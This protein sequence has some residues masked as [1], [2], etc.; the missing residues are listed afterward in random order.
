MKYWVITDTHFGHDEMVNR[1][2]RPVDFSFTILRHLHRMVTDKDVIIHLGDICFGKEAFWHDELAKVPG[3]KWLTM[4]N[5]DGKCVSKDTRILTVGGYKRWDEIEIGESIPTVNLQTGK[6]EFNPVLDKYVYVKEPFIYR[7][8]HG[9]GHME[10]S[11][12]HAII[13]QSGLEKRTEKWKKNLAENVWGAKNEIVIP[14]CFSSAGTYSMSLDLLKM[15]AW[16]A[17]D[18]SVTKSKNVILYQSKIQYIQEI[19]DLMGRLGLEYTERVRERKIE[20]ICGKAIKSTLP[21]HEF[22]LSIKSSLEI[23]SLLKLDGK[24]HF[25]AWLW[26]ISDEDFEIFINEVVKGDGTFRLN[27]HRVIWGNKKWLE[28][29]MGLCVTHGIHAN[30]KKQSGKENYYLG[31]RGTA[32]YKQFA[33]KHLSKVPYDDM[34]W[35]INVK[36]NSFFAELNG[37]TFVTGNSS[38]WYLEHGWDFVAHN[39]TL[40]IYGHSILLSHVPEKD[41]GQYT[42]EIHGHF[43]NFDHRKYE[44]EFVAIANGKQCVMSI[45]T[46]NYQPVLLQTVVEAFNKRPDLEQPFYYA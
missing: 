6:V 30:L 25:P 38:S 20:Y 2:G 33:P 44:P 37:N 19:K 45:E 26:D 3:K 31:V 13:Y 8:K 14:C 1:G 40:N 22:Y 36:N 10:V 39:F 24:Y 17:T 15:L 12:H 7:A 18:G 34:V 28:D 4:G 5:H 46:V 42:L 21:Q 29:L 11:A 43:H 41:C 27:K 23:L 9:R 16:I 32:R 35:C